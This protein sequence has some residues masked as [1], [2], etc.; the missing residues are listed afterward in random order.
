[1]V[2]F[3]GKIGIGFVRMALELEDIL[4]KKVD[5]VS[6]KSFDDRYMKEVQPDF[7]YV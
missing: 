3:N 6:I 5:L 4:K 7:L 1:M 2:E